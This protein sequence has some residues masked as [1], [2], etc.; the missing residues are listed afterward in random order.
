MTRIKFADTKYGNSD[1]SLLLHNNK[2]SPS[3]SNTKY[4][5]NFNS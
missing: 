5:K 1:P 3:K 4:G 2:N